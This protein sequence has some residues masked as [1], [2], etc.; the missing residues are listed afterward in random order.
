MKHFLLP[1]LAALVCGRASAAELFPFVLPWDDASPG[2]VSASPDKPAGARGFVVARDGH[3]YAGDKRIRFWGVNVCFSG[4]FPERADAEKIAAR[5]AK[6][7]V[8]CVRFHHMDT[9][10]APNGILQKDKRTLDPAQL[11]KLDYFIA[12]LKAN[13]VYANLNL[14]V[15]RVYPGLPTWESM[16]HYHKGV[17]NFHPPMIEMQ[18]EYARDL[19][20]HLNPYTKTRYVDEP[21]VA[22]IEINNE[23][24]LFREWYDTGLE[25]IPAVIA[26]EFSR[27]WNDWLK[28]KYADTAALRRAWNDGEQPLGAEMLARKWNLEQHGGAKANLTKTNDALCLAITATGKENWHVQLS[29]SGLAVKRGQ[30]YTI[31]F[32]A[33]ADAPRKLSVGISQTNNPWRSLAH[34]S[35]RLTREWQ[36]FTLPVSPDADEPNARYIFSGLGL[37]KCAVHLADL[38]LKPG[39]ILG[40]RDGES[41]GNISW[42]AKNKFA[43]RSVA[44]Q[45]DWIHFLWDTETRYWTGMSRFVKDELKARSLVLGT[46]LGYSPPGVQSQLDVVDIHSYWQ[47][48]HFPGRPWDM[49]NWTVKNVSMAA[50]RDGGTLPRLIGGRVPGK[51]YICTE[52]NH[53]APNVYNSEGFLMIA[54]TAAREDWDGVFAFAYNHSADWN[55]RRIRSFFDVDQ[56][57]TQ[58]ATFPAAAAMFCSGNVP[59]APTPPAALDPAETREKMRTAGPWSLWKSPTW[60]QTNGVFTVAAPR[61]KV[62]VGFARGHSF[63]L[64]D[65]VRV[66]PATEWFA[67]S[68]TEKSPHRWLVTATGYA[69]NTGMGWKNAEKTTVGRD[70]GKAPSLVE[71]IAA[72]ITLPGAVKVWALDERGQRKTEAPVRDGVIEIGPQFQTL[73]YEVEAR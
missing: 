70:W 46:Q 55:S 34:A 4:A 71:G 19:L 57:P 42:F 21:A 72:T 28:Q 20:T 36:T 18:K 37:E 47:H 56:H 30:T 67:I 51:P 31:S 59:A 64:G 49:G 53:P 69:E 43:T 24:G 58:M 23:N 29:Q 54:A 63:D 33:K 10:V 26:D 52:Y 50:A 41:L 35:V 22:F 66:A 32:R 9:S 44:A 61:A 40:L 17:D 7:G 16:P 2:F 8:N 45:R 14:H 48:P 65:G 62:V 11:E 12:Q 15:G 68:L 27:Q 25:E 1:L 60:E 13:G 3:L 38:S 39:G 5:M 6:F 73:W